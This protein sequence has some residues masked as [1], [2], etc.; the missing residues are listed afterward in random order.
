M[1]EDKMILAAD[2]GGTKTVLGIYSQESGSHKPLLQA[3]FSSKDYASL[4]DI[5][6]EFLTDEDIRLTRA[7]IG[8]AGPVVGDRAQV[9]NLPWVVESHSLSRAL[10]GTPVQLLND[11]SAIAHAIPFL[12]KDDI[13]TINSAEATQGGAKAVIAPG[14]GLGEGFLV[15]DGTRYRA[16]PSEGGHADF[17][18]NNP[19]QDELLAYLRRRYGHVSCER[20]CSGRGIPDLYAFFKDSGRL[21]EPEWLRKKLSEVE[22][23]TPVIVNSAIEEGVEI[24]LAATDLF[25]SILGSE[26][27]N[28]TLKVLATGGVYLAGGIPPR[29]LPQLKGGAFMESFIHKGRFTDFL[30]N[31]PVYVILNPNVGLMGAACHGLDL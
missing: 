7:S 1:G 10:D 13:A 15:W 14:T 26:A 17:A 24:S 25:I 22:D 18:S 6:R 4:E 20:V 21:S 19:L 27:G 28:M 12:E 8:V 11:L 31:V 3:K 9:T 30:T 16:F 5:I 2:I 29:I 23:Q